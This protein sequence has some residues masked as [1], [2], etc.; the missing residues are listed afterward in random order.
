MLNW[1]VWIRTVW[2]NG[3]D[4]N[5]NVF[6]YYTVFAFKWPLP[7]IDIMVR[8]FV[9][10]SEDLGSIPSHTKDTK[11]VLDAALLSTQH[12]IVKI[13]GKVE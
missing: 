10:G 6:V 9:N 4:W 8:V 11:M 2:L 3:I 5:R 7:D 1:I 13:K 12:Y